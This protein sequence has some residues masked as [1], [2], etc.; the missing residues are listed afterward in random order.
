MRDY[1]LS[2]IGIFII[3][4]LLRHYSDEERVAITGHALLV[5]KEDAFVIF[6]YPDGEIAY[7][8]VVDI[9]GLVERLKGDGDE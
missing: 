3:R 4:F 7:E 6:S 8:R 1:I 2:A 5:D 9:E